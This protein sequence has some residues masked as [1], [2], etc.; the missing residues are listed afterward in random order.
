MQ[1]SVFGLH[2]AVVKTEHKKIPFLP[3]QME[4][5]DHPQPLVAHSWAAMARAW[6]RAGLLGQEA[7]VCSTFFRSISRWLMNK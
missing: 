5:Q 4:G 6:R 1:N 7:Q 3:M 2:V